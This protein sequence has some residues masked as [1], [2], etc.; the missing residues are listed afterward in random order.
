MDLGSYKVIASGAKQ[1]SLMPRD[2]GWQLLAE[3]EISAEALGE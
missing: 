3:K 1:L 2:V